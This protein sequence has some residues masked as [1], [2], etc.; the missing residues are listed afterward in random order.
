MGDLAKDELLKVA[1]LLRRMPRHVDRVATIVERGDLRARISL[2]SSEDDVRLL[3]RLLNRVLLAFLGGIVGFMSVILIGTDGRA[4]VH[5]ED[6][7]V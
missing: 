7:F 2:L 3:T 5:R 6:L 4:R 1:P